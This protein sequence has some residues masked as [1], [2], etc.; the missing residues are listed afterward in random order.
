MVEKQLFCVLPMTSAA[1]RSQSSAHGQGSQKRE[2]QES[3][4]DLA[5]I[6]PDP[7][8]LTN[9]VLGTLIF[10]QFFWPG[11]RVPFFLPWIFIFM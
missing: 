4:D 6:A 2:E 11:V 7:P 8:V 1:S 5:S 9:A 3:H 10:I